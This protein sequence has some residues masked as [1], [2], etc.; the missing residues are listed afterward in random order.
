VKLGDRTRLVAHVF[1]ES[2]TS[3]G[4]DNVVFPFAALG[5]APQ[6]L[7]YRGEA[8]RLEIGD[9]NVIREH[10]TLS[11]GTARGRA[12]TYDRQ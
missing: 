9:N 8:T 10:A 7:S 6:D 11:R 3:L 4:K 12:V 1:I 2:H 5:G